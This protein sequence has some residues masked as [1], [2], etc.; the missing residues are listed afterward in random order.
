MQLEERQVVRA[1]STKVGGRRSR[2]QPWLPIFG[3]ACADVA[4]AVL[5]SKYFGDEGVVLNVG[6]IIGGCATIGLGV[7]L[8][9]FARPI[10]RI[11]SDAQ[12]V[13][14]GKLGDEV[15]RSTTHRTVGFV[16]TFMILLGVWLVISSF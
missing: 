8:V 2:E 11:M 16:G 3:G 12:R 15:A 10:S 13:F 9:V 6:K 4:D 14:L 1:R 5:A 7:T